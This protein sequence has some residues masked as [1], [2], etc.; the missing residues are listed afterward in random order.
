MSLNPRQRPI[1]SLAVPVVRALLVIVVASSFF[2]AVVSL[3]TA[4]SA[5]AATMACC[6]GKSGHESGSC[7]TG[8]L[9]TARKPQPEP[10]VLCGQEPATTAKAVSIKTID[11]QAEAKDGGH[12]SLQTPSADDV[13]SDSA[14]QSEPEATSAKSEKPD[15]P[16]IHILSSP[17]PAECGICSVSYT[18]RPR[19]REQSTLAST[20]RP[21]LHLTRR[22]LPSANP[23]IN[24]LNA[25]WTQLRPRAPPAR[26]S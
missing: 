15:L 21:R 10:E 20:A 6:I 14:K 22:V 26:L 8:L 11:V 12:C 13:T 2:T 1:Q 5:G 4:S 24:T 7:S 23:Q 3:G 9:Q 17:C 25:K 19:P 16:D 18:R